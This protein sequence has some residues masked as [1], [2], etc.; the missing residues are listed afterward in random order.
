[1]SS[2]VT[3]G[4]R[5]GNGFSVIWSPQIASDDSKGF[6]CVLKSGGTVPLVQKVG[7]L[8]PL[9]SPVNY[10]YDR[11]LLSIS[12]VDLLLLLTYIV[13]VLLLFWAK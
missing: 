8:V 3:G 1:M 4:I 7:V 10:G 6:T 12:F 13:T 2:L 11:V 9:V 5:G